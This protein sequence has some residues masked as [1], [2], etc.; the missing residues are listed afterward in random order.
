[1]DKIA[2]LDFGGQYAHLIANR[3]RRLNVYSEIVDADIPAEKLKD[4]K[5]IIFSGGPQSVYDIDSIK[6]DEAILDLGVPLLGICYGHQ[7]LAFMQGSEVRHDKQSSEFGL[8]NMKVKKAE[9]LFKSLDD[10]EVVWM[11]HGDIVAELPSGYEV[12]GSTE[13]GEWAAIANFEKNFYGVQF[14]LEVTHTKSGMQMLQNFLDLCQVKKEWS[15]EKFIENEVKAI[16]KKVGDKKVFMLVSGGVDSTVAFVLLSRALGAERVYGLFVDTGFLRWK[17]REKVEKTLR[18]AGFTNLHVKDASNEYY[19]ALKGIFDPELKRKIIGDLFIEVQQKIVEELQLDPNEWLLGQGTIYPDTIESGG[20]KHAAKIKTHHNRVEAIEKLIEEGKVIEPIA[21]LYKDEVRK[22][23]EEMGLPKEMVWRHPFPGPGLAVR[24]L[25]AKE[26]FY[27]E[28]YA[29]VEGKINDEIEKTGI[30]ARILPLQSV[31]VQGDYRTYRNPLLLKINDSLDWKMINQ[32]ATQL[33]NQNEIV[34]RALVHCRPVEIEHM[35][36]NESFLTPERIELLQ[37][38]DDIVD[39][40]IK[41]NK[42]NDDI[43]QFPTVLAP[44]SV[45][46]ARGETVILRPVQSEEAMTANF[47]PMQKALLEE[48]CD[49]LMELDGITAVFFDVTNKP[50]GTIEW[51]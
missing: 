19:E 34:N 27:P 45:N 12:I 24:C 49:R 3:I 18:N 6:A 35:Y 11:S 10:E 8:T 5:G 28:G 33:I 14:H 32:L 23:G 37:K 25:C 17:E 13:K 39:N 42:I 7:L 22:V 29:V 46:S 20:T 38:A 51:E 43:W 1:M 36:V 50:P 47:Y 48:L 4:Y 15:I 41:E 9:G 2:V 44:L 26:E 21:Q 16:E 30:S 40:F 31:G